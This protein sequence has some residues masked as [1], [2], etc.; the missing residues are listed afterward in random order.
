MKSTNK[1][2]IIETIEEYV[3][4]SPIRPVIIWFHSN[5]DIDNARR[6]I[7]EMNGCATCG[8]ALYIDKE[9]AIQTLTPSGD[10]K[11]FIIPGT[12]DESTKFFPVPP[13][14]GAVEN[15]ISPICHRLKEQNQPSCDIFS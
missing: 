11:Q 14:Y 2:N 10:D 9:G 6:A 3:G 12:Y 15:H 7:S 5:H 4:S 8:Q 13:L 1:D